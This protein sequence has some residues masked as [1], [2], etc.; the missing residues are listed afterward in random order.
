MDHLV[1]E[2][3]FHSTISSVNLHPLAMFTILDFHAR[4]EVRNGTAGEVI[5]M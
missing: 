2:L 1:A 3:P 4:R 5:G